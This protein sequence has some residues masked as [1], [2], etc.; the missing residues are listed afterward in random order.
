VGCWTR[1]RV[2]LPFGVAGVRLDP[3]NFSAIVEISA[4]EIR[5]INSPKVIW[6]ARG[7]DVNEAFAVG[8]T[9]EKL[10]AGKKSLVVK[11]TGNDPRLGLRTE[12]IPV[13]LRSRRDLLVELLIHVSILP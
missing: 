9:A 10:P 13:E 6:S 2:P 4:V 7:A 12:S 8:G 11:S 3:G 5:E 1:V